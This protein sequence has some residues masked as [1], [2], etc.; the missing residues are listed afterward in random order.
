MLR[1]RVV[2]RMAPS[3][4]CF[5][6]FLLGTLGLVAAS[7]STAAAA[8]WTVNTLNNNNADN[9]VAPNA[10]NLRNA[11]ISAAASG[12]LIDMTSL[13][14][15]IRLNSALPKIDKSLTITGPGP[16]LLAVDANGGNR[17]VF[18]I[19]AST[20]PVFI[21]GLAITGGALSSGDG[22]G[23]LNKT[24]LHL[25][26]SIIHGNSAK[27][28][29]GI[30]NSTSG[31]LFLVNCSVYENSSVGA[32]GAGGAGG[33]IRNK[34]VLNA[35]VLDVHHNIAGDAGGGI[36]NTGGLSLCNGAIRDN[37]AAASGGGMENGTDGSVLLEDCSVYGNSL[38]SGGPGGGIDSI[39]DLTLHHCT[40]SGNSTLDG[41]GG[42]LRTG[43]T[44]SSRKTTTMTNCT[45]SGNTAAGANNS[46]GGIRIGANVDTRIT[47]CTIAYNHSTVAGGGVSVGAGG[48]VTVGST[49]ISENTRGTSNAASDVK[50]TLPRAATT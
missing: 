17:R 49:I 1:S 23:I 37:N 36:S 41:V 15:V 2:S 32:G 45:V 30:F 22:G 31:H 4:L 16:D 33:G 20:G 19:D 34:G 47:F 24:T 46:G 38:T 9:C 50:G 5:L 8:T 12:D 40:I 14:G 39:G 48:T 28:G 21:S 35:N 43:G 13:S 44:A 11:I 18:N 29:G 42:G 7:V 27:D 10:C 3:G 25:S 6:C 26:N